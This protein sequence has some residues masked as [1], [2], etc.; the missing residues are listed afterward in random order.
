MN[1][2]N[3]RLE[4]FKKASFC[5]NFE[6]QVIKNIKEKKIKIPTYVSAGQE[7]ISSTI[8]TICKQIGIKPLIFAQHRCHSTYLSFGG[9]AIKLIDEL[10]GKESGCTKGM[11]GSASIHSKEINMYGHDG[12]MGTNVPIGIGACFASKK[13]TIIFLGDA[14]AE[15]DY[16]LGSLGWAS[17]KNIPLLTIIEDNNLSILTE[18]KVRRNW[19]IQDVAKS[20]KIESFGVDDDPISLINCSKNFFKTPCLLNVNTHRI[21]W[22]AGSGKDSEDTFDRYEN[23]KE[24]LGK[25]AIEIEKKVKN[26]VESLWEKQLEKQ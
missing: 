17:T 5:R 22:H 19:E 21:Y 24:T 3:F 12:L 20:F 16:V 14:A 25:E 23:E 7:F 13:P 8:A 26:E 15:E 2:K 4:V 6:E 18:K 10:L 1:E 11:G 9:D